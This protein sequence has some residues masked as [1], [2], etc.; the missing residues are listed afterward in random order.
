MKDWQEILKLYT[1]DNL[2]LAECGAILSRNAT[3]EI[4]A[5]KRQISKA[6]QSQLD[7]D[8]KC[9]SCKKQAYEYREKFSHSAA[10][11]GLHFENVA[12]KIPTVASVGNQLVRLMNSELDTIFEQIVTKAR[13]LKN[14]VFYYRKFLKSSTVGFDAQQE[15]NCVGLLFLVIGQFALLSIQIGE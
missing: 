15:R 14:A 13:E 11:L 3:Y 10:T 8:K 4:P 9:T 12:E 7:C 6:E 5:M 2:Y 1:K